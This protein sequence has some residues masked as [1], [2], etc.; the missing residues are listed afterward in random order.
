MKPVTPPVRAS[1]SITMDKLSELFMSHDV[2]S[3]P[4]LPTLVE[5]TGLEAMLR[6]YFTGPQSSGP[7]PRG[8]PCGKIGQ[9]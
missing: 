1:D 5:P 6:S 8:R 9:I 4:E 2:R 3:E 7:G